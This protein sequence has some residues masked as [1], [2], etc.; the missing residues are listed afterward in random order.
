MNR[1]WRC[2]GVCGL[3]VMLVMAGC[4]NSETN[5]SEETAT[6]EEQQ[7][8]ESDS[9]KEDTSDTKD[10]A[11]EVVESVQDS[12]D[13][14]SQ[15]D[16]SNLQKI[17]G[18]SD[19]LDKFSMMSYSYGS[20][21]GEETKLTLNVMGKESI[22]GEATTHLK[23]DFT[24]QGAATEA[25]EFWVNEKGE[26]LKI[27]TGGNE[28]TG[29]ALEM[30]GSSYIMLL[31]MPFNMANNIEMTDI[32]KNNEQYADYQVSL[33]D[34]ETRQVGEVSMET[35]IYNVTGGEEEIVWEV[36]DLGDFKIMAGWTMKVDGQSSY[37]KIGD[38]KLQN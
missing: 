26:A 2:L 15:M 36:G 14:A 21:E 33:K 25:V 30:V 31:L 4:G 12:E 29:E 17:D 10:E 37:F 18:L 20:S 34:K 16:L 3:L 22:A 35:Y 11:E 8:S 38:L 28:L 5:T 6:Q 13:E 7:A 19:I 24:E 1:T 23:V 27:L 32:L 9:S